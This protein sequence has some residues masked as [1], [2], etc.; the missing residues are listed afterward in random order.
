VGKLCSALMSQLFN[1]L[2]GDKAEKLGEWTTCDWTCVRNCLKI[3]FIPDLNVSIMWSTKLVFMCF[4][5][6]FEASF[7]SKWSYV[8]FVFFFYL[9]NLLA[10]RST[11]MISLSS[12]SFE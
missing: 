10:N 9:S 4:E 12:R 11:S 7:A 6:D 5:S 1:E 3:L 2:Q 8:N